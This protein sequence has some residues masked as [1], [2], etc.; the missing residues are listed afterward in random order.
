MKTFKN[1]AAQGDILIRRVDGVP[2]GAVRQD[3][4]G[5]VV[6]AHSETGHH[7]AFDAGQSVWLYSTPDQMVS[8][9]EVKRP[10]VLKHHRDFD[11][12]E[13]ILFDA[14]TYEI[15]RQRE[16]APEGWRRVED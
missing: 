5:P 13:E 9:L 10:A 4:R 2:A 16:W 12:H 11:T 6:V 14:G 8:Y 3:K 1:M 15:R 7:H